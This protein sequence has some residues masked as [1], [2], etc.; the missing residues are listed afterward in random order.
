M[1]DPSGAQRVPVPVELVALFAVAAGYQLVLLF[2]AGYYLHA[3]FV[4]DEHCVWLAVSGYGLLWAVSAIRFAV[5]VWRFARR[6]KKNAAML[7]NIAAPGAGLD[8]T[9][10]TR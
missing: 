10:P 3:E 2:V 8:S 5:E 4:D 9:L 7:G 6:T 1:K